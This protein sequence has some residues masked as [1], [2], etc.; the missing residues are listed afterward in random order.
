MKKVTAEWVRKAEE[1][2]QVAVQ[3]HQGP[4]P[5]HNTVC[6]HCQQAA[7][8]YLKAILEENGW[9]VP[10]THDLDE[11]C[12]SLLPSNKSLRSVRRGLAFLTRFAVEIRYPGDNATK[13]EAVAALRWTG[14][15]RME[16]RRL[17][18]LPHNKSRPKK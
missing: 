2:Y 6:F 12:T 18:G 10:K 14:K 3:T 4:K 5:F 16:A 1:D 15:V 7:E 17:L 11:L 8:K 13:R 9:T